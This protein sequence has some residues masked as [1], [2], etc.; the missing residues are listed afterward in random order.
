MSENK[1]EV[2]DIYELIEILGE[3]KVRELFNQ[4][5][6]EVLGKGEYERQGEKEIDNIME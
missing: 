3:N 2:K 5:Y 4:Y 1:L 6:V